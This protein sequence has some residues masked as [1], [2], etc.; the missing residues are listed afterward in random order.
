MSRQ[1]EELLGLVRDAE[2]PTQADEERVLRG[3]QAAVA[4]GAASSV[5]AH[6]WT[7]RTWSGKMLS[8]LAASVLKLSAVA[9]CA[10]AT[11]A[12]VYLLRQPHDVGS[13]VPRT[14][15][16]VALPATAP[17]ETESA[18]TVAPEQ[19]SP[20]PAAEA[21]RNRRTAQR[22]R[23]PSTQAPARANRRPA[24]SLREEIEMLS[25]VQAALKRG[26]GAAAL[27][28]LDS[29]Q[30]ADRALLAERQAA[31]I[32]ALCLVGRVAEARRAAAAFARDNPDSPHRQAIA[33]SCANPKR[34]PEP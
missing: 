32:L 33:S 9:A 16:P 11:I 13:V 30:T 5:M 12:T 4:A 34:I 23:T 26:D 3:L 20:V 28:E 6:A 31:R 15:A 21:I 7:S 27:H 22:T 10:G 8:K 18:R 29:H 14:V 2:D 25:R 17:S 1:T 19:P 24:G